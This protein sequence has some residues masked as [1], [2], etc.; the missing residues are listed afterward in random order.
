ML[1]KS[2]RKKESGDKTDV[3]YSNKTQSAEDMNMIDATKIVIKCF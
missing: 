2:S 1:K 3:R